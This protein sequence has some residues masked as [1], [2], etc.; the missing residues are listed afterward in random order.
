VLI[1]TDI[2]KRGFGHY[3]D[4]KDQVEAVD[5]VYSENGGELFELYKT[6]VARGLVTEPNYTSVPMYADMKS[7]SEEEGGNRCLI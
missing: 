7:I 6:F 4:F 3:I 5:L 1:L 2:I